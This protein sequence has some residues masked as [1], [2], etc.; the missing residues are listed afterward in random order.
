MSVKSVATASITA[1]AVSL[2]TVSAA[3]ASVIAGWDF[4]QYFTTNVLSVDGSTFTDTLSANYSNFDP[5]SNA[6]AESAAFGTMYVDG[7][8][9]STDVDEGAAGAA[10]VPTGV[11]LEGNAD[12]PAQG[13]GDNPFDSLSILLDEG[14]PFANHFAMTATDA[15]SVVFGADLS[16]LSG[17]QNRLFVSFGGAASHEGTVDVGVEFSRDGTNFEFL[18]TVSLTVDD[19]AFEVTAGL[20]TLSEEDDVFFRFNF[21]AP[22]DGL[23]AII[24]NVAI[25]AKVPALPAGGTV[26]LAGL[27][28]GASRLVRPGRDSPDRA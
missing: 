24:D 22:V 9:G 25:E 6:G 27:L 5:T 4:S 18:D 11:N 10:W 20:I 26:V 3:Q 1:A 17:P 14:Q 21:A 23:Q 7:T 13:P 19:S 2:L 8:N 28:L 16:T 15:V 12:A